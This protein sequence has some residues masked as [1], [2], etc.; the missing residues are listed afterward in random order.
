MSNRRKINK[1]LPDDPKPTIVPCQFC[2]ALT[3][4]TG[5][6]RCDVCWEVTSRLGVFLKSAAGRQ[7]V[8]EALKAAEEA[9]R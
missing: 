9:S 2:G 5:T 1:D 8:V 6:K 4:M 7:Y 3:P